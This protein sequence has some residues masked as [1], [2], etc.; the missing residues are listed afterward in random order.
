MFRNFLLKKYNAAYSFFSLRKHPQ[1]HSDLLLLLIIIYSAFY[2][3]D[4]FDTLRPGN[5]KIGL[6]MSLRS[7]I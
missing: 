4:I 2:K 3:F 1:G 6:V 5:Y 7:M